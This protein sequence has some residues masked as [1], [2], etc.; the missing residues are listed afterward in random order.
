MRLPSFGHRDVRGRRG[1]RALSDR[2]RALGK[3]TPR[4]PRRPDDLQALRRAGRLARQPRR[5]LHVRELRA[6]LRC[7]LALVCLAAAQP[8][9]ELAA[10]IN[11]TTS[12][13]DTTISAAAIAAAASAIAAAAI[14]IAAAAIALTTS[15]RPAAPAWRLHRLPRAQLP[16]LRRGG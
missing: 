14:A 13:T 8:S 10:P 9:V 6:A 11:L 3:L 1:P 5:S 12:T 15:S 16:L 7:I 2:R 4:A